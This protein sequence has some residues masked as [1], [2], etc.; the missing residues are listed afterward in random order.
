MKTDKRLCF[1]NLRLASYHEVCGKGIY[2]IFGAGCATMQKA[3]IS[4]VFVVVV[5]VVSK[6][7]RWISSLFPFRRGNRLPLLLLFSCPEHSQHQG[8]QRKQN[9]QIQQ[10]PKG[11]NAVAQ[12]VLSHDRSLCREPATPPSNPPKQKKSDP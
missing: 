7:R 12:S 3:Q 2:I 11:K 10:A 8:R 9:E 1:L 6:R 4:V 5:V